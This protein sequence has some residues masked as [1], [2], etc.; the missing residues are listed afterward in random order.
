[1]ETVIL[2]NYKITKFV[3]LYI[4]IAPVVVYSILLV[5]RLVEIFLL[6]TSHLYEPIG[7]NVLIIIIV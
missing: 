1:M 3:L 7:P 2:T 4:Y 5:K 6:K